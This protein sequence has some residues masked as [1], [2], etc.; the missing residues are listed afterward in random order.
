VR[1]PCGAVQIGTVELVLEP[2]VVVG[3]HGPTLNNRDKGEGPA[4]EY[5]SFDGPF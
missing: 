4:S 2:G 3:L 5:E 1:E